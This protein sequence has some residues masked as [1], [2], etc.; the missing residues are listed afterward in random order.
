MR[1]SLAKCSLHSIRCS[2]QQVELA[3][4]KMRGSIITL[5]VLGSTPEYLQGYV[6]VKNLQSWCAKLMNRGEDDPI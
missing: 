1:T 4:G 6:C 3:H 2:P 5:Q